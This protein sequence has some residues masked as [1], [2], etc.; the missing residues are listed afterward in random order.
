MNS[1]QNYRLYINSIFGFGSLFGVLPHYGIY[2]SRCQ[3]ISEKIS[4]NDTENIS[5]DCRKQT[6]EYQVELNKSLARM[7]ITDFS[8]LLHSELAF[9]IYQQLALE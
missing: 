4:S 2:A 1:S 9:L 3:V 8:L 6:D 5:K 7:H